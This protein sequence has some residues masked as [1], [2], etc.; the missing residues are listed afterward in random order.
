MD[1]ASNLTFYVNPVVIFYAIFTFGIGNK[2]MYCH[3]GISD[4]PDAV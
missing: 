1:N 4:N 2:P 3:H